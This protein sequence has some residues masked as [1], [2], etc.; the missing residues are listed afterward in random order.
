MIA[1]PMYAT[2]I[3]DLSNDDIVEIIKRR[4]NGCEYTSIKKDY[5]LTQHT[6]KAVCI[7]YKGCL[8]VDDVIKIK[9]EKYPSEKIYACE[10]CKYTVKKK[11]QY[12]RHQETRK[13]RY[14]VYMKFYNEKK[15]KLCEE[16]NK[17]SE[18]NQ[19][20]KKNK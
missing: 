11:Y 5:N 6:S 15:N 16:K 7:I 12:A 14:A 13:H 19:V 9:D 20:N 8:T 10:M 4:L 17:L 18:D 1:K 2:P 3:R